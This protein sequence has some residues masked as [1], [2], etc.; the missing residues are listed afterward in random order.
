MSGGGRSLRGNDGDRRGGDRDGFDPVIEG[1]R[2]GLAPEVLREIWERVEREAW[3]LDGRF[4]GE[5]ARRRFHQVAG[6]VARNGGRLRPRPDAG[7]V[8]RVEAALYGHEV[9]DPFVE[10][11]P[12]KVTRV[13]L[14]ERR[15]R[16]R[17]RFVGLS[18]VASIFGWAPDAVD[19]PAE[20]AAPAPTP[21]QLVAIEVERLTGGLP[22]VRDAAAD[23]DAAIRAGKFESA[24]ERAAT[25][26][27][28]CDRLVKSTQLAARF[29][30]DHPEH[31]GAIERHRADAVAVLAHA[32]GL[33]LRMP[34]LSTDDVCAIGLGMELGAEGQAQRTAWLASLDGAAEDVATPEAADAAA[35]DRASPLPPLVPTSAP[36]EVPHR[37]RLEPVFGA[38][39]ADVRAHVGEASALARHGARGAA[40]PGT[41]VFAAAEPDLETVAHELAHVRQLDQAGADVAAPARTWSVAWDAAEVEAGAV[42]HDVARGAA[43]VRVSARPTAAVSFDTSPAPTGAS[44]S[45]PPDLSGVV[46]DALALAQ[47]GTPF[48]VALVR[49]TTL[50]ARVRDALTAHEVLAPD[51]VQALGAG[52]RRIGALPVTP[53]LAGQP[54][55]SVM[56]FDTFLTLLGQTFL[57]PELME[58]GLPASFGN[59]VALGPVASEITNALDDALAAAAALV[60]QRAGLAPGE[61]A[62]R[63]LGGAVDAALALHLPTIMAAL[64]SLVSAWT[65]PLAPL[66]HELAGAVAELV[67]L[68]QQLGGDPTVG[69]Q[70]ARLA[71]YVLLLS[72]A[73]GP[74]KDEPG[75][76]GQVQPGRQSRQKQRGGRSI[77]APGSTALAEAAQT[78]QDLRALAAGDAP[79]APRRPGGADPERE[80]IEYLG[81]RAD[82]LAPQAVTVLAG[83]GPP[84]TTVHPEEAFPQATDALAVSGQ[85]TIAAQLDAQQT[86]LAELRANVVPA[87]IESF[88]QFRQVYARWFGFLN[89]EE[90]DQSMSYRFF[91]NMYQQIMPALAETGWRGW[92]FNAHMM[93]AGAGA[94]VLPGASTAIADGVGG[95][96]GAAPIARQD[97]VA[98]SAL[99]PGYQ[100]AEIVGGQ[101]AGE[102][103]SR[104]RWQQTQSE[105]QR[106]ATKQIY[107]AKD[108]A[109][110]AV[111][112]GMVP[113]DVHAPPRVRTLDSVQPQPDGAAYLRNGAGWHHF[114]QVVVADAVG[115]LQTVYEHKVMREEVVQ[116]LL[117]LMQHHETLRTPHV[118]RQDGRALGDEAA[119]SEGLE[120]STASAALAYGDRDAQGRADPTAA[121]A[122]ATARARI[123]GAQRAA[124]EGTSAD[125]A[126][127]AASMGGAPDP[128]KHATQQLIGDLEAAMTGYLAGVDPFARIGALVQIAATEYELAH[129]IWQQF[130]PKALWEMAMYSLK[131]AALM[132][133]LERMGPVGQL[134]ARAIQQGL[135]WKHA[136]ESINLAVTFG[137]WVQNAITVSSFGQARR[138]AMPFVGFA[139]WAA[140]A[141]TDWA[142]DR[143]G[144]SEK[145]RAGLGK[146]ADTAIGT[147]PGTVGE[148]GDTMGPHLTPASREQLV[149]ELE[150]QLAPHLDTRQP[151][152]PLSPEAAQLWSMLHAAD[153]AAAQRLRDRHDLPPVHLTDPI[154]TAG[155]AATPRETALRFEAERSRIEGDVHAQLSALAPDALAVFRVEVLSP[156]QFAARFRTS[157]GEAAVVPGPDGTAV[158]YTIPGI[159]KAQLGEE[160]IHLAQHADPK[161]NRDA[162][163]LSE[164]ALGQWDTMDA[165][166][167]AD[168]YGLKLDLEVDAAMRIMEAAP[169]NSPEWM[170]AMMRM[171]A[172]A[173]RRGQV[174]QL[175]EDQLTAMNADP[176]TAPDYLRDPSW[177]FSKTPGH[178]GTPLTT[179][180]PDLARLPARAIDDSPLANR[181][182]TKAVVQRGDA[183]METVTI[184]ASSGGKVERVE[185]VSPGKWKVTIGGRTY[186]MEGTPQ[187]ATG[188]VVTSG[189]LLAIERTETRLV[190]QQR[191]DGTIDRRIEQKNAKGKWV[192][193]GSESNF[194]GRVAEDAS[195]VEIDRDRAAKQTDAEARR[196]AGDTKAG[197]ESHRIS[198]QD[199]SGQGFDDVVVEFHGQGDE[200]RAVIRIVEVK[201]YPDK[202]VPLAKFTAIRDEGGNLRENMRKLRGQLRELAEKL[203]EAQ[204]EA[205]ERAMRAKDYRVEIRLGPTTS[206]GKEAGGDRTVLAQLRKELVAFFEGK[207]VLSTAEPENISPESINDAIAATTAK[208]ENE[209]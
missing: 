168:L 97:G 198:H 163:M 57:S 156:E 127:R 129:A 35:A 114:A 151:G 126:A 181:P 180:Q 10:I 184:T 140:G 192:Q 36:V 27:G 37:A 13:E 154:Q 33:L 47:E 12:G 101:G 59:T 69:P 5:E 39:F 139:E 195:K 62:R 152:E 4:H 90:R 182:D 89:L 34:T 96:V 110:A 71:R 55:A 2:H 94:M 92:L 28:W 133:A 18:E 23:L 194:R 75:P 173:Q 208:P 104:R 112:G 103:D 102:I 119:A 122:S 172:L 14:E 150:A 121:D 125:P 147:M 149:R 44:A 21:A 24:M 87:Q 85:E 3:G 84:A 153:P 105:Q 72:Q 19:A 83:D 188:D 130:E 73:L 88:A 179:T 32:E 159:S 95:G 17:E 107:G 16:Q 68:R 166:T 45:A 202:G 191:Q 8:T 174:A 200:M 41:V 1:A 209:P 138:A 137:V 161:H 100:T 66:E 26:R 74:V 134:A 108:R 187:V 206:M 136:R 142:E 53:A 67:A 80:T 99:A 167:R 157:R 175:G 199:G 164:A 116:Y 60:G 115:R 106:A 197:Y 43:S 158:L 144:L 141:L 170:D 63:L 31:A 98:D 178:E 145:V 81:D 82:L 93:N 120:A 189:T 86:A 70:I 124:F 131:L 49:G 143:L 52:A 177:L 25:L 22:Y 42:A 176:S 128:L 111:E 207:D 205:L 46:G 196:A 185:E 146:A 169:P 38:S 162:A 7:K 65:D 50:A 193:A 148:L 109:R 201:D 165:A 183:W 30:A 203:P 160:A 78:M 51:V 48:D 9:E 29:G 113:G 56:T 15:V 117:A 190:E 155:G 135:K 91:Q 54:G 61:E 76:G 20:V 79:G 58:H 118:A 77:V 132:V 186:A 40:M 204:Q 11:A 64:T 6:R 171:T 123:Q